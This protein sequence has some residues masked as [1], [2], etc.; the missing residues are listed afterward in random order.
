M[1][2]AARAICA[3]LLLA[4]SISVITGVEII[5]FGMRA[6]PVRSDCIIVLGCQVYGTVPSPFLRARLDEG[7]RLLNGG[8]AKYIIVS[9]ARGAGE[10]V[11][12]A[13][14]MRDYLISKGADSSDIIVEDRS[15]STAEN[16][17]FSKMKMD[18]MGFRSAIIVSNR[19]HLRRATLMAGR[20]GIDASAAGVFCSNYKYHEVKGFLREIPALLKYLLLLR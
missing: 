20:A 11:S 15:D 9:G 5:G 7:L 18:G 2:H 13:Q 19:F 3:I 4:A 6:K 12:E 10:E 14:A 16:I 8:Y 1:K 17:K